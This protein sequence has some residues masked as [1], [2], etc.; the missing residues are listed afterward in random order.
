MSLLSQ[1]NSIQNSG[2]RVLELH[3][4]SSLIACVPSGDT[5]GERMLHGDII[6]SI[7]FYCVQ[8]SDVRSK[9]KEI[10]SL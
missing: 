6:K 10:D 4:S 1:Y 9:S 5:P 3:Y 8:S 2:L 7:S